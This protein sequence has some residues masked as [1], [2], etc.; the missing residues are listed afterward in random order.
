MGEES[1][2]AEAQAHCA[3]L[4][5]QSDPDRYYATLFAPTEKRP[6][7]FALYAFSGEIARVRE[8]ISGPMPGEI[9]LQWWRDVL[10]GEARGNVSAHPVAVALLAGIEPFRLPAR[11][12]ST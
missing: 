5:R 10:S 7:L 12:S 6:H 8:T 11:R 1:P 3:S 2:L 9:R 4:V